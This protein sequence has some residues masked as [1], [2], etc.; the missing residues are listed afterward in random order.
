MKDAIEELGVASGLKIRKENPEI[1]KK[2]T[3]S[4]K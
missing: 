1:E 3:F 2:G 4:C